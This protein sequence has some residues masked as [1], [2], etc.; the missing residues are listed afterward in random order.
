MGWEVNSGCLDS[1]MD[2]FETMDE[3]TGGLT[4]QERGLFIFLYFEG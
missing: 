1:V 4:E 3:F 2:R